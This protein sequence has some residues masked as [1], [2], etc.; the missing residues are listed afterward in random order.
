MVLLL[1]WLASKGGSLFLV[2][3][4]DLWFSIFGGSLFSMVLLKMWLAI[5]VGS[6]RC[7]A[8]FLA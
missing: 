4:S 5:C 8:H 7:L 2:A 1:G 6:L 3:R